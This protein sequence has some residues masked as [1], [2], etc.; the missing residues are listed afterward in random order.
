MIEIIMIGFATKAVHAGQP[1]DAHTGAMCVPICLATT[2]AQR[3]PGEH[4]VGTN[5][6]FFVSFF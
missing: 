5:G 2:Y 4:K 1:P 6:E 3:S